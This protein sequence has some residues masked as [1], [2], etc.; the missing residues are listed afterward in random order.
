MKELV[1]VGRKFVD[2]EKE[3][4]KREKKFKEKLQALIRKKEEKEKRARE[5]I[6][7]RE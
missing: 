1:K 4:F 3:Y 6:E 7:K 2:G 5:K